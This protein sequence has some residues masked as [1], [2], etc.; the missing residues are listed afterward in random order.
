MV[1]RPLLLLCFSSP[2][3]KKQKTLPGHVMNHGAC[4]VILIILYCILAFVLL[5]ID[6]LFLI[7]IGTT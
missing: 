5:L 7:V 4:A 2:Y 3:T 1:A 6:G